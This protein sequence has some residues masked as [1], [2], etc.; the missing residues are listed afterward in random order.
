M[1]YI[2]HIVT[3]NFTAVSSVQNITIGYKGI[4]HCLVSPGITS[5][6]WYKDNRFIEKWSTFKSI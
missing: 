3:P 2:F 5:I 1:S 6:F 4:V